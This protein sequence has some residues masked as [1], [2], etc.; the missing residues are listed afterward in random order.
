MIPPGPFDKAK[1]LAMEDA[2]DM[3][4]GEVGLKAESGKYGNSAGDEDIVDG[5][6][7]RA[8]GEACREWE[9]CR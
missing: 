5:I 9:L 6:G 7:V 4:E 3:R 1:A 8:S 2:G